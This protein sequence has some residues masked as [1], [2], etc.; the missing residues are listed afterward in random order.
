ML[1]YNMTC[2]RAKRLMKHLPSGW[3]GANNDVTVGHGRT[4][5]LLLLFRM[6]D[7]DRDQASRGAHGKPRLSKLGHVP[8]VW[9]A[10]Q[11]GE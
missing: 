10:V 4:A 11:Y 9:A 1:A 8:V 6:R 3:G 5:G 2:A 7:M